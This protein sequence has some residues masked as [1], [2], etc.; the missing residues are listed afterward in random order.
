[1]SLQ[2]I[3][4]FAMIL[5]LGSSCMSAPVAVRYATAWDSGHRA[6]GVLIY[7][8]Q[9]ATVRADHLGP[10]HGIDYLDVTF[11][12]PNGEE[13]Y[14]TIDVVDGVSHYRFLGVEFNTLH[15]SSRGDPDYGFRYRVDIGEDTMTDGVYWMEGGIGGGV[16]RLRTFGRDVASQINSRF[17]YTTIPEPSA[18]ALAVVIAIFN[19]I[20]RRLRLS[21]GRIPGNS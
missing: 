7:D 4:S 21:C 1:M 17:T 16:L 14:S 12:A 19:G 8:N 5:L 13:L 9:F 20:H 2:P 18:A 6:E 15:P 10:T 11:F 3:R